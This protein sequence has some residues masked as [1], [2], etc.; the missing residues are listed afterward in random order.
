MRKF[1]TKEEK[2]LLKK[3]Y[4]DDG[5]SLIELYP[6]FTE[7][8]NRTIYSLKIK[9]VKFK[10]KHTKEQISSIK[11]RLN[12]GENNGMYGKIGPNKGLTK[13]NSERIKIASKKIS[14]KRKEMYNNGE[15]EKPIGCKNP[16]FGIIPW[17]K[18]ESK[19]TNEIIMKSS[20]K[21]SIGRKRYWNNL[22]KEVQD[23][24][25]GKLSL[26]ANM[27]KKDTK[28]EIIIK[29]ALDELCIIYIKN[30]RRGRYIFDFYLPDYNYIIEC[31]GDYWHANP[32]IY[33][34]ENYTEAQ[35]VNVERDKRKIKYI[36]DNNY[37][38]IF[39]WENFIHK[40][41]NIINKILSDKIFHI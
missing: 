22:S 38:Y 37:S 31:Q 14:N 39:L 5:L 33:Q 13:E 20:K 28:I 36:K 21:I 23:E 6:I 26:Y 2:E 35:K 4:E 7:L 25:I 34:K 3:L 11:S 9:I 29:N 10:L 17:N 32:D 41:K 40:N 1:W 27:A 15:I 12:S 16:M 30:H 19:Y 8:Y 18:G 24:I